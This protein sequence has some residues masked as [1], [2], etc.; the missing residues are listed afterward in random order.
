MDL[1]DNGY[2]NEQEDE[3]IMGPKVEFNVYLTFSEKYK[4]KFAK[5]VVIKRY[6][7]RSLDD[8]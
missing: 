4:N 8:T 5:I 1:H 2:L 3:Y 7:N 6:P